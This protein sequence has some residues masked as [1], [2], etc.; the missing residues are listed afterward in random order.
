[1]SIAINHFL[2]QWRSHLGTYSC[3]LST[4][5]GSTFMLS[6]LAFHSS[7]ARLRTSFDAA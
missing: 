6:G 3:V 7:A 5:E 2:D 1:M 4:V